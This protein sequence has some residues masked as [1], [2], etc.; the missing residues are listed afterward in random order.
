MS[1]DVEG[2]TLVELLDM[3]EPCS[4]ARADFH[5]DT[6]DMGLGSVLALTL[7]AAAYRVRLVLRLYWR[8]RKVE[9]VPP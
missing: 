2:K 1:G 8:Y 3:L 4:D 9:C 7:L 6:A 5:D